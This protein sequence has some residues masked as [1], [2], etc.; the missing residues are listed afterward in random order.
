MAALTQTISDVIII[1]TIYTWPYYARLYENI[2]I[3]DDDGRVM[4]RSIALPSITHFCH[5]C[6]SERKRVRACVCVHVII[7]DDVLTTPQSCG[8]ER[9]GMCI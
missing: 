4:P 8:D 7:E 6:I 5:V 3:I 2:I 1:N 9:I